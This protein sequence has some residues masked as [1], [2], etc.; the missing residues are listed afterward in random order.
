M[1]S[2]VPDQDIIMSLEDGLISED[3]SILK[4]AR[5]VAKGR[6]TTG[7]NSLQTLL[8]QDD[9]WVFVFN[10]IDADTV[11][12]ANANLEFIYNIF[13][14][15]HGRYLQYSGLEDDDSKKNILII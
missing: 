5:G 9:E 1:C 4:R 6:I 12:E 3:A 14:Q 7:A 10:K 2:W 13:Q 15:L 11:G 8:R